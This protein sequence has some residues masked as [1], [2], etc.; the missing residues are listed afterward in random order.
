MFQYV[1]KTVDKFR[2]R[3]NNYKTNHRNILKG[4]TCMPQHLFEY[5]ASEGHCSY[6][7]DVT[8]IFADKTDPKDPNQR[9]HYWRH[10]LK[11]MAPLCLNVVDEEVV[12]AVF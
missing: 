10:T 7:E 6:L 9:E 2:L 11:T 1:G 4:E 5:F 12:S 3:W 8:I